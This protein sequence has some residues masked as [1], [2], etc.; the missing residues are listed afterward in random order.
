[1]ARSTFRSERCSR[2]RDRTSR[3]RHRNSWPDRRKSMG[4]HRRCRHGLHRQADRRLS[5]E[6]HARR[7]IRAQSK[8]QHHSAA[9]PQR[10]GQA[11]FRNARPGRASDDHS[12]P[13]WQRVRSWPS[14]PPGCLKL[15]LSALRRQSKQWLRRCRR[16][17]RRHR[18]QH[19]TLQRSISLA[20]GSYPQPRLTHVQRRTVL[21]RR[22]MGGS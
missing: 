15:E 14:H 2:I 7:R 16:A 19:H 12:I 13:G 21:Y 20:S 5:A 11:R 22:Q 18:Q 10:R 8:R 6:R 9:L 3:P 4:Q 17:G 1:M